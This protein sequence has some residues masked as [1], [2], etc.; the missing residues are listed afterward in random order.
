MF[1]VV[2]QIRCEECLGK[3]VYQKERG[4]LTYSC[5]LPSCINYKLRFVRHRGRLRFLL[6][7]KA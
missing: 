5:P 2:R 7:L 1:G 6:N 3:L 4:V